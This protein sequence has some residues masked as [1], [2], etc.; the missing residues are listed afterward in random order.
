MLARR[1]PESAEELAELEG[2]SIGARQWRVLEHQHEGDDEHE[3]EHGREVGAGHEPEH[4]EG[5]ECDAQDDAEGL[6]EPHPPRRNAALGDGDLVGDRRGEAGVGGVDRGLA[7]APEDRESD[8]GALRRQQGDSDG[9]EE[10]AEEQPGAAPTEARG[11]AIRQGASQGIGDDCDEGT[12]AGDH[13]E[14]GLLA[15]GTGDVL[16]EAR[17]QVL[18]RREEGQPDAEVGEGEGGQEG[19]AHAHGGLGECGGGHG[20]RGHGSEGGA[21]PVTIWWNQ[22]KE[23]LGVRTW[24]SG[25]T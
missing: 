6:A 7:Q 9:A 12:D 25:S 18:N 2:R 1:D 19:R 11:G 24:V 10:R 16:G 4:H 23:S 17:Q 15:V 14:C 13:C 5:H 22:A 8:D 3:G 20:W 21:C